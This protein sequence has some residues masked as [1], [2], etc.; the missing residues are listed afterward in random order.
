MCGSV[1]LR[2]GCCTRHGLVAIVPSTRS[3]HAHAHAGMVPH[4]TRAGC[5]RPATHVQGLHDQAGRVHS[6][7]SGAAEEGA[8]LRLHAGM[9]QRRP[10]MRAQRLSLSLPQWR[11]RRV[12]GAAADA[13]V[14]CQVLWD[15]E[16]V[17]RDS[18]GAVVEE[19]R[20]RRGVGAGMMHG[21]QDLGEL[22]LTMSH[23]PW[24][25][26]RIRSIFLPW[27]GQEK[28][29]GGEGKLLD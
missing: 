8:A 13:L 14:H 10:Q 18:I 3:R 4:P 7:H 17:A 6:A 1:N 24:R 2:R 9:G 23:C 19:R 26:S 11:Q 5:C 25:T 15:W 16:H 29:V 27:N 12:V 22:V 21:K 20:R 28:R